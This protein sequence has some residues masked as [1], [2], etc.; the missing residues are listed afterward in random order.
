M[1]TA[2]LFRLAFFSLIFI[3]LV[4]CSFDYSDEGT[5]SV[6]EP[7]IVMEDVEYT[8]FRDGELTLR[9]NAEEARRYESKQ[10]M[11]LDNFSFEQYSAGNSQPSGDEPTGQTGTT[12]ESA[13]QDG[14][15]G[16]L[17]ADITGSGGSA[18]IEL[19]PGNV[20]ISNGVQ[21]QVDSEDI[22]LEASSLSWKD[23]ERL[24]ESGGQVLI[25]RS[26]GTMM[27][28]SNFSAD[29]RRK[30]WEFNDGIE[31]SY[32]HEEEES[33]VDDESGPS[34][35]DDETPTNVE[36]VMDANM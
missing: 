21:V 18:V 8:R 36:T 33:P 5:T 6:D 27:K 29:T 32:V 16:A 3:A 9:F 12:S 31:G 30:T 23:E 20:R 10:L 22:R 17:K 13:G 14:T 15:S 28:G 19:G 4:S 7:D 35:A 26:D 1:K 11:E 24:L 2:A 34:D 25:E